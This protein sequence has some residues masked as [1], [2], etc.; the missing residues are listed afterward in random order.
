MTIVHIV[1]VDWKGGVTH[2]PIEIPIQGKQLYDII[3]NNHNNQLIGEKNGGLFYNGLVVEETELYTFENN[4]EILFIEQ[5]DHSEESLIFEQT[6]MNWN[7][8]PQDELILTHNELI[9]SMKYIDEK[10][11]EDIQTIL[12]FGFDVL[13]SIITYFSCS[14]SIEST[15]ESLVMGH[16]P[17]NTRLAT[18]FLCSYYP[19]IVNKIRP[20]LV[21]KRVIV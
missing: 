5:I 3:F 15:I 17:T 6:E 21:M 4:D 10:K 9:E 7:E 8:S 14:C 16:T 12:E 13:I 20:E 1:L 11:K 19:D 2:L 18:Q